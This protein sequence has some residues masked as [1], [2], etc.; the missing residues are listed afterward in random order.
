[1]DGTFS[2]DSG[3]TNGKAGG[4]V[5]W[6][7]DYTFNVNAY[8]NGGCPSIRAAVHD[9]CFRSYSQSF[10]QQSLSFQHAGVGGLCAGRLARG[11]EADRARGDAVRVRVSA[12][13]A[14]AERGAG[15]GVW[16]GGRD[17]RVSGGQEQLRAAAGS[18]VGAVRRG[19]WRG[20]RWDTG[21]TSASCRGRRCGRR[22]WIRRCQVR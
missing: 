1:M 13:A 19:A 22:C 6:I 7:T 5:D 14:A 15:C 17:Q 21:C 8:P 16:R 2:Y 18:G 3:A 12:A 10:G 4:L 9:F 20:A 11:A